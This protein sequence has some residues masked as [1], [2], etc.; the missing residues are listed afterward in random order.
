M[1]LTA[2]QRKFMELCARDGGVIPWDMPKGSPILKDHEIN[3]L[4]DARLISY[5]E[6]C[7]AWFT[8]AKGNRELAQTKTT[9]ATS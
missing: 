3:P 1:K 5:R 4:T 6:K 7:S 2:R 9:K 8:T